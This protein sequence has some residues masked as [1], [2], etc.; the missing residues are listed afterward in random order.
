[1]FFVRLP[2]QLERILVILNQ[3]VRCFSRTLWTASLGKYGKLR[4]FRKNRNVFRRQLTPFLPYFTKTNLL[5]RPFKS[6]NLNVF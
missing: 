1:M 2:A 6:A 3:A 4:F 5:H